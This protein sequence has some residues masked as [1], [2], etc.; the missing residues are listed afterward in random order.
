MTPRM[1][2]VS[3]RAPAIDGCTFGEYLMTDCFLNM[4]LTECTI[5]VHGVRHWNEAMRGLNSHACI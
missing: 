5:E 4:V 1:V 2:L 3:A